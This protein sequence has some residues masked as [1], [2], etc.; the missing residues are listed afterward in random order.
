MTRAKIASMLDLLKSGHAEVVNGILITDGYTLQDLA[1]ITNEKMERFTHITEGPLVNN[2][3]KLI[4]IIE[5]RE[6]VE[7]KAPEVVKE[8]VIEKVIPTEPVVEKP[9]KKY[10]K[11]LGAKKLKK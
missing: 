10:G 7:I 2:L 4:E 1:G 3:N 11:K 8:V 9:I 5:I 6:P